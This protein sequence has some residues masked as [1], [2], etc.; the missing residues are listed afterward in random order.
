M[1]P[2]SAT[3][4][5]RSAGLRYVNDGD[6]GFSRRRRGRGFQYLSTTGRPLSARQRDRI[7][8][9]AIPPAWTDVWICPVS[10]GHIQATGRDARGRKQYLY[11]PRWREVRD[12]TKYHRM[13]A[14][15]KALPRIRRRVRRDLGQRK[16]SR[17]R[18]LAAVVSLLD[19]T[20]IRVGNEE[21]ARDNQSF[22]LATMRS[23]HVDVHGDTIGFRFRGKGGKVHHIQLSDARI[24]RV[25]R[26]CEHL[27]GQRL[28]QY[29]DADGTAHDVG[30]SDVNEYLRE[31]SGEDFTAKEFRTWTGTVLAAW[32]L[33]DLAIDN[34]DAS[35]SK[36]QIVSAVETVAEELGNTPAIC[37]RCYVHP[38]VFSAHLDGTLQTA[39]EEQAGHS[40][41]G[42]R[43]LS[44]HEAAV[45][46]LL[47]GRLRAVA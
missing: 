15:G 35:G 47:R 8:S 25:V 14:F 27:P 26:R 28:F 46:A 43:G 16:L 11:H 37:R 38:D 32:A 33:H 19:R 34:P 42:T 23:R 36:A 24:A 2:A 22:G 30:S 17:E 20:T 44:S 39:L 18:V 10:N 40:L 3:A 4:I 13:L 6:P 31:I 7:S 45:L 9:L 41:A 5:A 21:Y 1:P 12:E 29:L